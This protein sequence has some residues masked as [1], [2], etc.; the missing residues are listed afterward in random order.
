MLRQSIVSAHGLHRRREIDHARIR[1]FARTL[2]WARF[3]TGIAN[4]A[5]AHLPGQAGGAHSG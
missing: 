5:E 4:L 2:S 3:R 1:E